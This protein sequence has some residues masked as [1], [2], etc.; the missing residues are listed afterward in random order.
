MNNDDRDN[1]IFDADQE[2]ARAPD[3]WKSGKLV[4]LAECYKK[5]IAVK[6]SY[7]VSVLSG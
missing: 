5:V 2:V 6:P 3:Y 7:K 4:E 1:A